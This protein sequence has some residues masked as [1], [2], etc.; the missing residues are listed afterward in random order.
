MLNVLGYAAES[1]TSPLKPFTFE[2]RDAR[3]DDVT[4]D[5]LYSGVCHS[6]IHQARN[7]WGNSVFPMVPGHEIIGR[8]SAVGSDVQKYQVGDMVG[9]G[10]MVESCRHCAS[11]KADLEQYCANGMA[12]TYNGFHVHSDNL[13]TYGGY[14]KTIV[15]TEHFVVKIPDALDIKSA[16]PILCAGITTYSPLKHYGVKAGDKVGIIGMGGLGHMGVKY[17]RA[18]GAEVTIFTRSA[19]KV[20]EAKKQGADHVIVST[21]PAQMETAYERFDFM[22]DTVPTKHDYNPYLACLKVDGTHIIVGQVE[23]LDEPAIHSFHLIGKRRKLVGSMIGG[24]KETQEVLDFSAEHG[25]TCDVEM[26]RMDQINEAYE[27]MIKGDV[28]YRFVIDMASL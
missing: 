11:C 3:P 15:V 17:A 22:L 4:I 21:D 5:I 7:E 20:A 6:D 18:L 24:M 8:V 25:I 28:K 26:I 9:V 14:S 23:P 16:A 10:C 27:R 2:R 13:P 12:P 1:A 19:S